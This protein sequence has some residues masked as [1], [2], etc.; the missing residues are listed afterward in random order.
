MKRNTNVRMKLK[1]VTGFCLLFLFIFLFVSQTLLAVSPSPKPRPKGEKIVLKHADKVH[2]DQYKNPGVQIFIGNVAFDHN[3]LLLYC[4][5]ADFYQDD[6]SFKAFGHVRMVQ[7]DTLSLRGEYLFYDG[8]SQIAQV[9]RNVVL[10]HRKTELYTDSLNYDRVYN[11]GYFFEGGKLVDGENV[12]TSDWGQYDTSTREALFNYNVNLEGKDYMLSG[13]TL[14][15]DTRPRQSHM[16]GPSTIVNGESRIRTENGYFNSETSSVKLLDRSVVVDKTHKIVGDTIDYDKGTGEAR[17]RGNVVLVDEAN[18]NIMTSHYC[19][20]NDSTGYAI[21]Y[22]SA[23]IKNYSETDTLYMHADTFKIYTYNLRTDSAYRVAHA[24][25]HVR[26]Y[27]TDVQS[28]ADS[29]IYNSLQHKLSLFGNPIIWNE[30][31]QILGEE[32]FA[33]FNDSSIDSIHVVNQALMAE[34]LD[35]VHYNQVAGREMNFYFENGQLKENRVIGNVLVNYFAYDDDSLMIGMNHTETSLLRLFMENKQLSKIWTRESKGTFYPLLF[36]TD[37]EAYLSNF[38][39]FDYMRP[40]SSA[41]IFIWVPKAA[42]T[43]LK[44]T[45]RRVVPFQSLKGIKR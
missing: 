8:N 40:S 29:M 12:L 16:L 42:G 33:Y 23:Q 28:V 14:Y 25:A 24:F 22:D 34:R 11:M 4:D 31:R 6:N 5:S 18:K 1:G 45:E 7:G 43:E 37:K 21:A 39:W 19:Y 15:Y 32:I 38:A 20:Y 2:F 17:A 10:R 41:D 44:R 36:V 30:N 13:D 35:S 9:R 3:G 27:R 26:S